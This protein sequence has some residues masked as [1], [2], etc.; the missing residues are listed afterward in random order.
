MTDSNNLSFEKLK[1]LVEINGRINSNYSDVNALLVYILESAMRLVEC[2][3]S[4][5]LLVNKE[6]DSLHFIVALGPKGTEAK[7]IL[8]EKNS[9]AGWV[10]SNNKHVIVNNVASDPRFSNTVQNKTGYISKTMIAIPMRVK[11]QCIGVIELINKTN[12]RNFDKEDLEILEHLSNQAGIAYSNA[13]AFRSAQD[14]ISVLQSNIANGSD[15]HS[16]VGK[17]SSVEDLLHVISQVASTN[18]TILISGESGV[19]KELFAEQI[20]LRSNRNQK[21]FIRVNCAAL[22]SAL[23]ESEL[24]G[25][26]KGAFTDAVSDRKG[27]FEAANGGTIFLDEIGELPLELQAK[28]LRVLQ[29]HSFERVGSSESITVDVRVVAATNRDLEKMV[30]DGLFRGDLFYR[31]NVMPLNIPPLRERKEDILPL[32][33]FFLSKFS[34]ETKKNFDGFS[35]SAEKTLLE[36]YWPGNVRELENSIERACVLGKPP[37]IQAED[38]RISSSSKKEETS[39]QNSSFDDFAQD[40]SNPDD[41]DRTL[42]TAINKFKTAYVKKILNETS[43]NQTEAGKILGIQRTYVSRLLNELHIR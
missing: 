27:R 12:S 17:S 32:A 10:V 42:K 22:S 2:E 38:L 19:G 4:S 26:V 14:K 30:D 31:L 43:W 41:G 1:T 28:L 25:H 37:L 3:S 9:I 8:V 20:H 11:G 40:I 5:L 15:F 36:Y 21:P 29:N 18:T 23:L 6:D 39:V 35:S 34:I 33:K 24:F 7:N 13:D 16:F